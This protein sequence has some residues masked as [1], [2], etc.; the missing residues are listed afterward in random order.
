MS[1]KQEKENRGATTKPDA[2][3]RKGPLNGGPFLFLISCYSR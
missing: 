3:K 2:E 1:G